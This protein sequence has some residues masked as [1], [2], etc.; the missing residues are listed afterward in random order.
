MNKKNLLLVLFINFI[1]VGLIF[2]F[3]EI[4]IISPK[5]NVWKWTKYCDNKNLSELE[6]SNRPLN[7]VNA[8]KIAEILYKD[9]Q[10]SNQIRFSQYCD[11]QS[12]DMGYCAR[13]AKHNISRTSVI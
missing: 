2:I 10:N 5:A 1:I 9:W 3:T 6:F 11:T 8:E 13:L 12:I 7:K 4:V